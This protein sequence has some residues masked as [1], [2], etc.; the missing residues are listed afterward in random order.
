MKLDT[1][2]PNQYIL[3]RREGGEGLVV[4]WHRRY[5]ARQVA[6]EGRPVV[7]D[8]ENG[9]PAVAAWGEMTAEVRQVG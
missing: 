2:S 7:G 3:Y 1:K 4:T 5:H 8:A 6:G 9:G